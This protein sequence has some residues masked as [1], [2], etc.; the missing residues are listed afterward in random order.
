MGTVLPRFLAP[1]RVSPAHLFSL[2]GSGGPADPFPSPTAMLCVLTARLQAAYAPVFLP[3]LADPSST[4][5][6]LP[7]DHRCWR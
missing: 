4:W 6:H 2:V 1:S 3:A 5:A 7:C